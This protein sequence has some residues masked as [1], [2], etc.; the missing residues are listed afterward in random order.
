MNRS[1]GDGKEYHK[2]LPLRYKGLFG[3]QSFQA[4]TI[5]RS[6]ARHTIETISLSNSL[7]LKD[8]YRKSIDAR[9]ELLRGIR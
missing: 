2:N 1:A 9:V 7:G 3:L 5:N 6:V 4:K 8:D